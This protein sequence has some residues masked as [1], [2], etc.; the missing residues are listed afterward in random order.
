MD[1]E[2]KYGD[3]VETKRNLL[4]RACSLK[5]KPKV[6]KNLFT[7]WLEFEQRHNDKKRVTEVKSLAAKYIENCMAKIAEGG[8]DAEDD[9]MEV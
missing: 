7:K 4:R 8:E 6:M 5:L 9:E 3:D 2:V 1:M